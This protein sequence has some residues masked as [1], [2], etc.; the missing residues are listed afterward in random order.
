VR[1]DLVSASAGT[2]VTLGTQA[3]TEAQSQAVHDV[4]DTYNQLYATL[5]T[6]TDPVSGALKS[7]PA[8]KSL[9]RSLAELSTRVLV[10]GVEEDTPD[11]LA[12]IGVAT[13]RDGT[14]RVDATRLATALSSYGSNIEKM[15][16]SGAGLSSALTTIANAA[17]STVY[18]LGASATRYG[19]AQSSLA[20]DQ[21]KATAAADAMRERMTRQFAGMDAAVARYKSI[22]DALKN[23]IDA[24]NSNN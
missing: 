19:E 17:S 2:K 21:A 11:S 3:P 20:D 12:G 4:V 16:A 7:D 5:K 14:L 22:Q 15:F 24:W 13:N 18:G 23:Q 10:T 8:A 6:A 1:L 9:L